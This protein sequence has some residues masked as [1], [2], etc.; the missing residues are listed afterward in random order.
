[1]RR[2][3]WV[4]AQEPRDSRQ[5]VSQ[6]PSE[7]ESRAMS[8][9]STPEQGQPEERAIFALTSGRVL[10]RNTA[11]N[12]LGQAVPLLAALVSIPALV[13]GLG[14][15]RFGILSIAWVTIGYF[16][17]FDI[18]LGRALTQLVSEKL[19]SHDEQE[20]PGLVWTALLLMSALGLVGTLVV[21]AL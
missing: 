4:R 6:P 8:R 1:M 16:S 7:A 9:S 5:D 20:I 2:C 13:V 21:S 17:L 12:V 3:T 11:I 14:A 15:D 19:G 18:G 10:A